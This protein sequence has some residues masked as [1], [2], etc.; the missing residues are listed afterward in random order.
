MDGIMDA[1][2]PKTGLLAAFPAPQAG[3]VWLVGAHGGAGCTTICRSALGFW[4]D[5]GRALPLSPDPD[6]P[7]RFVLCAMGTSR[8]L[9]ALQAFLVEA[10]EGRFAPAVLVGAAVTMPARFPPLALERSRRQVCSIA[11]I[12]VRLPWIGSL[13]VDG[14]PKRWPHAYRT[15]RERC[16]QPAG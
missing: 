4:A 11:P 5:A 13:M 1:A 7:A 2:K 16:G 12:A 10:N 6:R 3:R 14:F 8:G 15:L 9:E